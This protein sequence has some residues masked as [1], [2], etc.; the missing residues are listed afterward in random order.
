ML[1]TGMTESGKSTLVEK[2]VEMWLE[3]YGQRARVLILD[4][5][6]RFRVR[7]RLDGYPADFKYRDWAKDHG[8]A[9]MPESV[10]L[11]LDHP[12]TALK[13]IWGGRVPVPH[14]ESTRVAVAQ[15]TLAHVPYLARAAAA[16]YN[17][18]KAG[19]ETLVVPDEFSD[20]YGTTGVAPRG[21]PLLQIIRAGREKHVS[22]LAG[23]Q[24]PRAIPKSA[25]TEMTSS[26][27]FALAYE[28][29]LEHLQELGFPDPIDYWRL[30]RHAHS[31]YHFDR[32][33]PGMRGYYRM[34]I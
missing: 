9:P 12:V 8:S 11:D 5:K 7:W 34:A 23:S 3:E 6:P 29:D 26:A 19:K 14:G 2:L 13:R 16:A 15:G 4:S 17:M 24:R 10:L 32:K 18:A 28:K 31:F 1:C 30:Q 25:L 33:R 27:I 20:F 22:F 21:D